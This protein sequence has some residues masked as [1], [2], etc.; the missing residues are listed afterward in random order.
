M[1]E[2]SPK[3]KQFI[4]IFTFTNKGCDYEV[5]IHSQIYNLNNL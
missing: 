4:R 2:I 5:T 3:N 1:L